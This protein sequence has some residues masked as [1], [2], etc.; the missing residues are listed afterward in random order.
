MSK[1]ESNKR[2]DVP[3]PA[4]EYKAQTKSLSSPITGDIGFIG[5]GQMGTAMAANLVAARRSVIAYVRRKEQIA[6]LKPLGI[7]ATIDMSNL[8]DCQLVISMLP[9]DEAVRQIVLA[10][11]MIVLTVL[12]PGC[13]PGRSIC[14]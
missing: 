2:D 1:S 8:L 14:R 9:D 7:R 10:A 3:A 5:L 13:C 4:A 6:T 11:R 12:P